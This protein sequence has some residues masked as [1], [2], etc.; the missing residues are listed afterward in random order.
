MSRSA[1][2][3]AAILVAGCA[4]PPQP[5]NPYIPPETMYSAGGTMAAMGGVMGT[6]VGASMMEKERTPATRKAGYG[7]MG[8][9]AALLGAA[10]AEA[11]EVEK[12]RQK[13]I[14]LHNA[15]VRSYYGSSTG[16]TTLR[17]PPPPLPEIPF[18]FPPGE[19]PLNGKDEKP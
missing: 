16:E 1:L 15:F 5:I 10:I 12:E 17:M 13:Y 9:G 2:L 3:F 7:V 18:E 4:S 8:G 11:I 14:N 6:A 19:S